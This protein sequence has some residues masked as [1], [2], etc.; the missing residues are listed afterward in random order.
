M[1]SVTLA[2]I[3]ATVRVR[4][5]FPS[6]PKFSDTNV[7]VEIQTAWA[8]LHELIEECNEGYWDK[9][10]T[11]PTVANQA[12]VA[13]PADAWKVKGVDILDGTEYAE[14]AQVAIG[15]R[16]RYGQTKD[17]PVAYRLSERG[18]ELYPTPN[19]IYTLRVTYARVVTVLGSA[20]T[21]PNDWHDFVIW[22]AILKLSTSEERPTGDYQNAIDRARAR[23]VAGASGRK[24]A[25]PEYL[26]LCEVGADGGWWWG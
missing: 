18:I 19:A 23:I 7:G 15:Q 26:P 17:Q 20:V 12:Y 9:E 6:S 8:E 24:Q 13:L 4:G 2:S 3:L 16:N 22:S 14:L 11:V 21:I 5:D 1:A 10:G 25:E